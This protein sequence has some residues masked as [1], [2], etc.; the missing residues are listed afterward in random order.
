MGA[1]ALLGCG[2]EDAGP[3]L[4]FG[5]D[6]GLVVEFD[7]GTLTEEGHDFVGGEF[8]GVFEREFEGAAA[9]EC[10]GDGSRCRGCAGGSHAEGFKEDAG[11][12]VA[13]VV[14]ACVPFV[15]AAVEDDERVAGAF[16]EHVEEVSCFA[17]VERED[18]ALCAI[19]GL[20]TA[21]SG[22]SHRGMHPCGS[23]QGRR[24][25]GVDF[26]RLGMCARARNPMPGRRPG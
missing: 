5:F 25:S 4:H 17:L 26:L 2:F 19:V 21:K 20:W 7:D 8:G 1:S 18:L 3:S 24:G 14:D 12:G 6:V 16:A 22:S 13:G 9:R 23:A 11:I 10:D 15:S